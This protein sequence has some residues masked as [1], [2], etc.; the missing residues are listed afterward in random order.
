MVLELD[1]VHSGLSEGVELKSPDIKKRSS[2]KLTAP[3]G[4]TGRSKG[5]KVDGQKG[6]KV[7]G[8]KGLKLELCESELSRNPKVDGPEI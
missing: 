6:L 4:L 1:P 7:N 8:P 2:L 3:V 5:S